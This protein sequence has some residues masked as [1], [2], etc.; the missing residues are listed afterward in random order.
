MNLSAAFDRSQTV[1]D[2]VNCFWVQ[3]EKKT[4]FIKFYVIKGAIHW[5]ILC[6]STTVDF[7]LRIEDFISTDINKAF[8]SCF[9]AKSQRKSYLVPDP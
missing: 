8:S 3:F 4:S 9:V 1:L 7:A 2:F 6:Y 5:A